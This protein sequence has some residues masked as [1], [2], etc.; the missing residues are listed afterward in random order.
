VAAA[1]E[2][3]RPRVAPIDPLAVTGIR[4]ATGRVVPYL[5]MS[6]AGAIVGGGIVALLT[7]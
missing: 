4:A 1:T 2:P 7:R 6:V 3:D 5:L